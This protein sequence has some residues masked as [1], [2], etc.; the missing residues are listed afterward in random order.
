MSGPLVYIIVLNWNGL[1]H[2]EKCL[3][4]V[5][6]QTY[7]NVKA[8]MVDNGSTDGSI[9]YACREFPDVELIANETNLGFCKGNNLGMEK[10]M[11]DGADYIALLNNDTEVSPGWV[12]ALVDCAETDPNIGAVASK[13]MM[14]DRRTVIN[15]TGL[16]LSRLGFGWDRAIGEEDGPEWHESSDVIGACGGAFFVRTEVLRNVGLLPDFDIYLEDADLS[17]R[18]TGAGHRI[19]YEPRAVVYHKFSATMGSGKNFRRKRY[20]AERNR[21]RLLLRNYPAGL[22][23]SNLLRL[24]ILEARLILGG[25]LR[26]EAWMALAELKALGAALMYLPHAL[27]HRCRLRS[28][29]IDNRKFAPLI[30]T[31][32]DYPREPED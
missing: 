8:L 3:G 12:E 2:L 27:A 22:L 20:L 5:T 21:L 9:E 31:D 19:V 26:R 32:A 24:A 17:L 23:A 6:A 4:S 18:I 11:A 16:L 1:E 13:M 10:A 25:F 15:S 30:T 28:M 29:G 14:F 7:R